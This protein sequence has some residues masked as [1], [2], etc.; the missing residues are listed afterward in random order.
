MEFTQEEK[1]KAFNNNIKNILDIEYTNINKEKPIIKNMETF[2]FKPIT[3][4]KK[5]S[6]YYIEEHPEEMYYYDKRKIIPIDKSLLYKNNE[7]ENKT[8]ITGFFKL[9]GKYKIEIDFEVGYR[10]SFETICEENAK[11]DIKFKNEDLGQEFF[12]QNLENE[13]MAFISHKTNSMIVKNKET[14]V[15]QSK[16]EYYNIYAILFKLID[17][18]EISCGSEFYRVKPREDETKFEVEVLFNEKGKY[19]LEFQLSGILK[20]EIIFQ[21]YLTCEQ[22]AQQKIEFPK[23][24]LERRIFYTYFPFFKYLS[25]KSNSFIAKN[26]EIFV[27]ES[28][29]EIFFKKMPSLIILNED[30]Y[31]QSPEV[32]NAVNIKKISNYRYEIETALNKKGKYELEICFHYFEGLNEFNFYLTYYPI[33]EKDYEVEYIIPI[34]DIKL[35]YFNIC[36]KNMDLDDNYLSHKNFTLNSKGKETFIFNLKNF[37]L[38]DIKLYNP[39]GEE[40]NTYI[41]T[42]KQELS[43]YK[44]EINVEFESKGKYDIIF[45]FDEKNKYNKYNLEYF[46]KVEEGMVSDLNLSQNAFGLIPINHKDFHFDLKDTNTL[47]LHFKKNENMKF[48]ISSEKIYYRTD[49]KILK[50]EIPNELFYT[51]GFKEKGNYRINI[52]CEDSG[53][54][55]NLIYKIN[56]QN[57]SEYDYIRYNDYAESSE[58]QLI[59][60]VFNYLKN[61]SEVKFKIASSIPE[62]FIEGERFEPMRKIGENIFESKICILDEKIG[63]A[64]KMENTENTYSYLCKFN[65]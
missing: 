11:E 36:M 5:L 25:Q 52:I 44:C 30:D 45:S 4:I 7:K 24:D 3:K 31:Y 21:Y 64:K 27:F 58:F 37:E 53:T 41:W 62:I 61:G 15:F 34:E 22:D 16:K 43:F 13:N 59:E 38:L 14:F 32:E 49:P 19:L 33:I 2:I 8:E 26:K 23:E 17:L 40:I 55:R 20:E 10:L 35:S 56:C 42:K 48:E 18:E 29:Y 65:P 1:D 6:L 54:F 47:C 57:D 28:K 60:P 46:I 12:K 51:L 63:I 39:K 50:A 9:K